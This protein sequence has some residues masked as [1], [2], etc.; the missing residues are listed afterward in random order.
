MEKQLIRVGVWETNSSS[1]HSLSVGSEENKSFVLSTILPNGEGKIRL[2]GGAYGWE[3]FKTNDSLEKANYC[4]QSIGLT[5]NLIEV[6]KEVTG[7]EEVYLKENEGA[8]NYIDHDSHGMIFDS[9]EWLKDFIFNKNSFLF[10]GNDNERPSPDF[11]DVS[12]YSE[13]GEVIL[14]NYKYSV[15]GPGFTYSTL[16]K[17]TLE[18]IE[19]YI[20]SALY[21]QRIS[22]NG[23]EYKY[24]H[25]SDLV[26]YYTPRDMD[27]WKI[28]QQ[29][30][31]I[32]ECKRYDEAEKMINEFIMTKYQDILVTRTIEIKEI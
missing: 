12:E 28:R 10:G 32:N 20:S 1:S 25:M 18:E 11:Y 7:A 13:T 19:E 23:K 24:S 2:T 8:Y 15:T 17:P 6:I 22:E 14:P 5:D 4:V 29:V 16:E 30:P 3:W 9:K 31:E 21:D 27:R 26:L